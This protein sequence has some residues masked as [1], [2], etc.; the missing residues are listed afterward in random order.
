M[1]TSGELGLPEPPPAAT[2]DAPPA[3]H[4]R[5]RIDRQVRA[6]VE[7]EAVARLGEDPEGVHQMRVAVRRLRAALKA[8]VPDAGLT[9]TQDELRWLGGVLGRIRDLDVLLGHLRAQAADLPVAERAAAERLVGALVADH[10]RA[11]RR[12][13]DTFR[14]VRYRSLLRAL[15]ALTHAELPTVMPAG[16]GGALLEVIARPHRKLRQ[17][18][19]ALGED[20]PDDDLH[21]LRIRGKRL[22]YAAELAA[23]AGGR[24]VRRLITATK[25]FQ[26][27]LGDH[28]DAVLAEDELRRLVAELAELAD[29]DHEAVFVAG[30]LVERERARRAACR[31][32]WRETFDEVD[33]LASALL[34]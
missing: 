5:V 22:R 10:R 9:A 14:T 23:P 18:A 33:V 30:R 2:P 34:A 17:D 6:L 12:M 24:P 27:V 31:A 7:H 29:V 15:A 21:A 32:R 13:L 25:T 8:V 19:L 28:Q 3:A 16:D 1:S 20:P 4:V 11:R 26:E